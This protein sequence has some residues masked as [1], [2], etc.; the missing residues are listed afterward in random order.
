MMDERG[1]EL[2]SWVKSKWNESKNE[3]EK[4]GFKSALREKERKSECQC[5]EMT[6]FNDFMEDYEMSVKS[7]IEENV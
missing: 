4:G 1:V 2:F 3:S 6:M 7:E 5:N